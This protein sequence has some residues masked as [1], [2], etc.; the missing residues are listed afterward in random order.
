MLISRVAQQCKSEIVMEI[1]SVKHSILDLTER[2]AA[3][4]GYL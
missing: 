3:L 4:R 2:V 1:N